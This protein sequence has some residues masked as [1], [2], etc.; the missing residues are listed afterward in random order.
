MVLN[1]V[2]EKYEVEQ[3]GCGV[4]PLVWTNAGLQEDSI[5]FGISSTCVGGQAIC[6]WVSSFKSGQLPVPLHCPCC[7]S[8]WG[9]YWDLPFAVWYSCWKPRVRRQDM[10]PSGMKKCSKCGED[11]DINDFHKASMSPDGYYCWCKECKAE[12]VCLFRSG[13]TVP[14]IFIHPLHFAVLGGHTCHKIVHNLINLHLIILT[15]CWE[16]SRDIQLSNIW[17]LYSLIHD[18]VPWTWQALCNHYIPWTT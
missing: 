18:K 1:L 6:Q 12:H 7:G 8:S 11:K 15:W 4:F 2:N 10:A 3:I 14:A 13:A 9:T 5:N 16:S 17:L